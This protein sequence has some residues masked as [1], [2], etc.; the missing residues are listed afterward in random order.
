MRES[1]PSLNNVEEGLGEV[2]DQ[3]QVTVSCN[4]CNNDGVRRLVLDLR[5][6]LRGR[7]VWEM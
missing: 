7:D 6:W 5:Q 2:Q 4:S 3:R 1:S